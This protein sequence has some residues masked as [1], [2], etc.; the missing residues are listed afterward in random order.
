[1]NVRVVPVL[2]S[3]YNRYFI[4]WKKDPTF[5]GYTVAA[6]YKPPEGATVASLA[7]NIVLEESFFRSLRFYCHDTRRVVTE[8]VI[9][10]QAKEKSDSEMETV[11][12][13]KEGTC[14]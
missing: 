11:D 1:M 3:I 12:L 2:A 9:N 13:T 6:V 10:Y 4:V 5:C 14:S 8:R 7:A